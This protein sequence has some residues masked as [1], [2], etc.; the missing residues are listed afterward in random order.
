MNYFIITVDTEGDNLWKWKPGAE[1]K[2]ENAG[3]ISR[4]QDLCE[5]FHF[6][7]IYLVNYEM[8][9]SDIFVDAVRDKAS[10]G[11]CE[12]GMHLHA[13]N[14]PPEYDLEVKYS[15]NPYITEYPTEVIREKHLFLKELIEER[16]GFSPVTY[17]AGRWATNENLFAILEELGFIVDCS[18]TPQLSHSQLPGMTVAGGSEYKA[19]PLKPYMVGNKLME[20]PMTTRYERSAKGNNIRNL[21]RNILKGRAIWLRPAVQTVD[22]M[23]GLMKRVERDKVDNVEF[24]I[25]SSELLAGGSPYC[26]TDE[27]IERYYRKMSEVFQYAKN[28]GYC[29]ISLKDYYFSHIGGME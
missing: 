13:W 4:F 8:C 16:F 9:M 21:A 18:V 24:M 20:V 29:G 17:R 6:P 28:K 14:S 27:D 12:I 11:L 15:G 10:A 1:I 23:I 26:K 19:V 2:T 22:E 25:H 5:S 7:P 3:C